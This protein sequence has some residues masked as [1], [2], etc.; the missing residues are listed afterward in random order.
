MGKGLNLSDPSKT[1][2]IAPYLRV[3]AVNIKGK[4]GLT[5]PPVLDTTL[6]EPPLWAA[7]FRSNVTAEAAVFRRLRS[8][9][10]FSSLKWV[11]GNFSS[12]IQADWTFSHELSTTLRTVRPDF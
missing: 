2:T 9:V 12:T 6:N 1:P 11:K 8:I 3:S 5:E 7:N 4:R 10:T